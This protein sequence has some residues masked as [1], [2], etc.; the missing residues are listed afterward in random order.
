VQKS[1]VPTN[2]LVNVNT[3]GRPGIVKFIA[4]GVPTVPKI[5]PHR[6]NELMGAFAFCHFGVA[7]P[8]PD[9]FSEIARRI[10]LDEAAPSRSELPPQIFACRAR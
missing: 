8:L 9:C 7:N 2:A 4:R 6:G 3:A 10:E 1:P 5:R